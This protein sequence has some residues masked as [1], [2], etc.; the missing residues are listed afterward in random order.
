MSVDYHSKLSADDI[1]RHL[2]NIYSPPSDALV[3]HVK[4]VL[5]SNRVTVELG[6][7]TLSIFLSRRSTEHS[8]VLALGG[9][10]WTPEGGAGTRGHRDR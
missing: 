8:C 3:N 1:L 10:F 7:S 9:G 4:W 6:L 2:V 5:L